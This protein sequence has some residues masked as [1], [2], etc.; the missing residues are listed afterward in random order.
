MPVVRTGDSLDGL[1]ASWPV[2]R[3]PRETV[4]VRPPT[5]VPGGHATRTGAPPSQPGER[6]TCYPFVRD[7]PPALRFVLSCRGRGTIVAGHARSTVRHRR[8][9]SPG[10]RPPATSPR[11][12]PRHRSKSDRCWTCP[13]PANP[14]RAT[15]R[16]SDYRIGVGRGQPAHPG[17]HVPVC[18]ADATLRP[19]GSGVPR[20]ATMSPPLEVDL[21]ELSAVRAPARRHARRRRRHDPRAGNG[22]G[23]P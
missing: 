14:G 11:S 7:A 3:S 10:A 5:R 16:S 6:P 1:P 8:R 12:C 20:V 21:I 17:G 4:P 19:S 15:P 2:P 22:S 13:V 23:L 18:S 9:A